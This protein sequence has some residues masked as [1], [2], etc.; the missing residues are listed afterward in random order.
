MHDPLT[1]EELPEDPRTIALK[2]ERYARESGVADEV[3]L[4]LG[5][6][7]FLFDGRPR[8]RGS[9]R[10]RAS[11]GSDRLEEVGTQRGA[12]GDDVSPVMLDEDFRNIVMQALLDCRVGVT[13]H[14]QSRSDPFKSHLELS[15][16]SLVA[17]ADRLM[18]T[19][20]I[21][22]RLAARAGRS[23]TFMPLP[24]GG[25]EP[26]GML[27]QL[28]LAKQDQCVLAGSGYAGLSDA[29]LHAIG[30]ILKHAAAI[31]ALT[32][33]TT[34]SYAR[35]GAHTG[36]LP[37][38]AYSQTDMQAALR[39][40]SYQAGKSKCLEFR[41]PDAACNPY[42][43]FAALL[44]AAIDG[45]QNKNQPGAPLGLDPYDL[46][47]GNSVSAPRVPASYEA[48]LDAL[49]GDGEFLLRGDVLAAEVLKAWIEHKRMVDIRALR[50]Q[51]HPHEIAAYYDV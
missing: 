30:G 50:S 17:S 32:N 3:L 51:P 47:E 12:W 22:K 8:Q 26:A 1:R 24:Q 40:P 38:I 15:A 39:V 33:A 21:V 43:A 25:R 10:L 45:V 44:M 36:G 48:A 46:H 5:V 16:A 41:P 6:E 11:G 2:A 4:A 27:T 34:N 7:F 14:H 23:A 28:S 9:R 20:H 31:V 29:G 35:L 49:E 13:S 42:L 37:K 19:K 18:I